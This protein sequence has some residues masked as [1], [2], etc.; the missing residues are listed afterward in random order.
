VILELERRAGL[1]AP[2][3]LLA[4]SPSVVTYRVIAAVLASSVFGRAAVECRNG[5][6]DSSGMGGS[7]RRDEL[8]AAF[9]SARSSL[10]GA[11]GEDWL[12]EPAY[13]FWFIQREG[14]PLLALE[15]AA[16]LAWNRAGL[17]FDMESLWDACGHRI[18][19]LASWVGADLLV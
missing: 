19:L 12:E 18:G 15:P 4:S 3:S 6:L 10:G 1:D 8:F 17:R 11:R 16:G 7:S 2:A 5:V 14:E 9:P 13:R